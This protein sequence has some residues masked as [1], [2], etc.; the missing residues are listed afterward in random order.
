MNKTLV[1]GGGNSSGRS[2][3]NEDPAAAKL[4]VGGLSWQTS[5]EKLK[6]YFGMFGT[7]TDVLIMKDPLT[8]VHTSQCFLIR[9]K[10]N[11]T[12]V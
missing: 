12:L 7:V 3:P 10:K 4:F 2:S 8:Q 11:F 5:P 9:L 1:A 6:E